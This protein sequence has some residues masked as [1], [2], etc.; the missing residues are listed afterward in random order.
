MLFPYKLTQ[1][2]SHCITAFSPSRVTKFN[3]ELTISL[4]RMYVACVYSRMVSFVKN[5]I[6]IEI[7]VYMRKIS[8]M[9][10]VHKSLK[11]HIRC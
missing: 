9:T 1:K 4:L 3:I 2:G 8:R 10:N 7:S 11:C 6:S 5:L